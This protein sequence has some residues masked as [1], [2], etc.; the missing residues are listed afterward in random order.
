MDKKFIT[1]YTDPK[2][3]AKIHSQAYKRPTRNQKELIERLNTTKR[4]KSTI[5]G[6]KEKEEK[7]FA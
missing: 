3:F 5:E 1:P 7:E 2:G 4:Q 6:F